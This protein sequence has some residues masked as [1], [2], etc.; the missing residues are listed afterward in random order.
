MMFDLCLT[1]LGANNGSEKFIKRVMGW[2]E[3]DD[4][5]RKL[6]TLTNEEV[7]MASTE[8]LRVG[9]SIDNKVMRIC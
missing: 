7:A 2:K 3:L 1:F 5:L 9:Y 8:F 4:G 6:G